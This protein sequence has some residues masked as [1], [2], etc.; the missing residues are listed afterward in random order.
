MMRKGSFWPSRGGGR[1]WAKAIL[2]AL[3]MAV[4]VALAACSTVPD[5]GPVREGLTSLDQGEQ[6][7]LFNPSGPTK[8]AD[9]E[10]I[11]RGF[12]RAA[13]SSAGNY[14]IA[15]EFLAPVYADQW[16]PW[17]GVIVEEGTLKY[18]NEA[19]D[20]ARLTLASVGQVDA[21]GA[22]TPSPPG[23]EMNVQFELVQVNGEWRIAS[24][25]GGIILDRNT[26]TAVWTVRSVYFM[27]NDNRL[28]SELRWVLNLPMMTTQI[29][30]ELIAG[31][32]EAMAGAL[33]TAF[34][35]G[36][37]L[38]SD[39][40]PVADGTAI[41]DLSPELFDADEVAI[42]NLK[43]QLAASLRA[44][45]D[46]ERFQLSVHGSAIDGGTVDAADE[47]LATE[48]QNAV[49]LRE[50]EFGVAV[51]SEVRPLEDLS[52]KVVELQPTAAAVAPD[53]SAVAV[54]HATGVSW[55]GKTAIIEIDTRSR[56]LTPSLDPLGYVWTYSLNDPNEITV[57]VPG[58]QSTMLEA[59]WLE[60][61][62]VTAL[63]VSMGG[64]RIAAL[65]SSGDGNSSEVIVA[66]IIRDEKGDPVGFTEAAPTQM[67]E[68]GA[69]I[70]LDWI[71]DTRFTTLTATGLLG[72]TS[73]VTIGEVAGRLPVDS[74][75]VSS[76]TALS[77]GG[78]RA[79]LRVL[80]DQHRL[81][82]PQGGGWQQQLGD[83]EVLAKIG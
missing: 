67:W 52:A 48:V 66:G 43:R 4:T 7:V 9:K 40:V 25:P 38:M 10:A 8:G 59:P 11:V 75:T 61:H 78:S 24:A 72:G 76:G 80:D 77:G 22:M 79:L 6:R 70:D 35:E 13:S 31:P 53:L 20:V 46:V 55:V 17:L 26:F 83:V 5:S 60:G 33:Y 37:V 57:T 65:V 27:S 54:R 32:S 41:I 45:S 19:D 29:V 1:V 2:G 73:K 51:G 81:Y 12:V 14:A 30:R 49:V 56:L 21:T 69:P 50:G 58:W 62:Q 42:E 39:T 44:V 71:G 34:P 82:A 28:V 16:D 23:T 36:T 15:R 64:N 63:R 74:G 18:E 3:T 68:A 47:S